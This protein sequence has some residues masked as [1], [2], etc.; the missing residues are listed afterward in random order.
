MSILVTYATKYGATRGIAERIAQRMTAAGQH[1][2]ARPVNEVG[3][4]GGYD[5]YV[6]GSAAYMGSWLKEAAE[7]VRLN[8]A[9]LI[10]KPTWLFSS[11]PLGTEKKNAQGQDVLAS[12]E[13][14]EFAEFNERIKPRDVQVFFGALD[15]NR[16]GFFDRLVTKTPAARS[17]N[18]FPVGD[19]RDWDAI[20]AWAETIAHELESV[21]APA[22]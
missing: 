14:K 22:V 18:L 17:A 11:G 5:A 2:E 20:E 10:T 13:P 15:I 8:Q 7:F 21:V 4:P 12:A 3:D 9:T 1:A 16:L 6:I 19:F